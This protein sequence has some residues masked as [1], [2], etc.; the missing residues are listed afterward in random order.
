M[1]TRPYLSLVKPSATPLSPAALPFSEKLSDH[2]ALLQAFLDTHLTRNH[3]QSTL[4]HHR[5]FLTG[6]FK[7]F[8]VKDQ[9]HPEGER[10][11][12]IWEA[13]QPFYGRQRILE[14]S[15]GLVFSEL[16]TRTI[17]DYLGY[18]RRLFQF[19]LDFP[20]IP[21][22]QAVTIQA[23]YGRIE[24]PVSEYDYPV[25]S[26]D[27]QEEGFVLT[28]KQ[29]V[30]FLD[31]VRVTYLDHNQKKLPASRDYTMIVLAAE[32]GLRANEI[33]QLDAFG[34]HN[35]LFFEHNLIQTRFGKATNGSG[36]RVRKT[37]FTPFAQRTVQVFLEQIRPHFPNAKTDPALFLS[38]S[39]GRLSYPAMW[40]NLNTI[41]KEARQ[42]RLEF[43]PRFSWHSLRKSFATGFM[44]K[45]PDRVWVLMDWMG[46]I[47]PGTLHRY[48]KPD[49]TYYQ[50]A[51]DQIAAELV[52]SEP[53]PLSTK[54]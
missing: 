53:I 1:N 27:Q 11:L 16:K 20:Y 26:F 39:G 38:E 46:H 44:E 36:K 12:L 9:D 51:L 17:C 42:T 3:S 2:L 24:Q 22:S 4:D 30:D 15:K 32:S 54:E 14:F 31:F 13:M 7:G 28:G 49:R 18:L 5:R 19:V 25:H 21:G 23:K 10:Q 8:P 37:I 34:E 40:H 52:K 41:V 45:Y 43:P 47:S 29:L 48:V 35:D 6:W 33:L 50:Q